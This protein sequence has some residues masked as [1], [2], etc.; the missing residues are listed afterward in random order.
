M[1]QGGNALSRNP[2]VCASCSS[3]MDGMGD[4]DP[5]EQLAATAE[6]PQDPPLN[7]H[8]PFTDWVPEEA[9]SASVSASTGGK[10][11]R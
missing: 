2:N 7:A 5:M 10:K 8:E 6:M 1:T 3:M 4:S 9:V 11:R